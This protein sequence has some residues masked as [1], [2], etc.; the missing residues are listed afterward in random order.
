MRS[1]VIFANLGFVRP[2]YAARSIQPG[3][4]MSMKIVDEAGIEETLDRLETAAAQARRRADLILEL[5]SSLRALARLNGDTGL[6]QLY[7]QDKLRSAAPGG[8]Q[9]LLDSLEEVRSEVERQRR[10]SRLLEYDEHNA[11]YLARGRKLH[12][13]EREQRVLDLLWQN[14]EG[15]VSRDNL[16]DTLRNGTSAP[17]GGSADVLITK[18]RSKLK[19]S[20]GTGSAITYIKGKGWRLSLE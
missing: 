13:S 4:G 7:G 15:H 11:T 10:T 3:I 14:R 8:A 17:K 2:R 6:L 20:A 16:L 18:L 19:Q 1:T 12:L 9:D 5:V